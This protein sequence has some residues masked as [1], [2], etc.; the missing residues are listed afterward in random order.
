MVDHLLALVA[1]RGES[2][3]RYQV[4]IPAAQRAGVPWARCHA[5]RHTCAALLID[6]ASSLRPHRWMGR[7]SAAVTLD[8][9]GHL[10]DDSLGPHL[11]LGANSPGSA[12]VSLPQ[13]DDKR[14]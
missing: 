11:S 14:R 4:M 5:L 7:H 9:Y 6:G 8:N 10:F 12:E 1:D 2:D 3:L 13:S